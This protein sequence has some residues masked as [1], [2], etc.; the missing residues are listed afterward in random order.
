MT[1]N[2]KIR[3]RQI[4]SLEHMHLNRTLDG[5]LYL[6][7]I[8]LTPPLQSG[9][10]EE[11]DFHAR[12][13]HLFKLS[14]TPRRCIMTQLLQMRILRPSST[15]SPKIQPVDHPRIP[16]PHGY[17]L[18]ERRCQLQDTAND[19]KAQYVSARY[20]TRLQGTVCN[21]LFEGSTS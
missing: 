3:P 16:P 15:N 14:P 19:C 17:L 2:R 11:D 7:P 20:R 6:Q 8:L 18:Q 12:Q 9:L 1:K 4:S 13:D 5:T 21:Y 10:P